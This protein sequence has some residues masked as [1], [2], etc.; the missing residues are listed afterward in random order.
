[1]AHKLEKFTVQTVKR[2]EIHEAD[3]N[4][5][6]IS[7]KN[8]T[9]LKKDLKTFGLLAPIVV[10]KTTGN[11]VAGHQRLSILDETAKDDYDIT[12]AYVELSEEDEI[13]ANVLMNNQSAMGE[14][15]FSKLEGLDTLIDGVKFDFI[16]DLG[17]DRDDLAVIGAA[18]G[19]DDFL[20]HTLGTNL[21][22]E[23]LDELEQASQLEKMKKQKAG[24]RESLKKLN[25]EGD[26]QNIS[27][28]DYILSFV[29]G[30]TP[31]KHEFMKKIQKKES[32]RFID[33]NILY[34]LERGE[35]HD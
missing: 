34:R 30:S 28:D 15:D 21:G 6:T 35:Y 23:E 33:A 12:V 7:D 8:R 14:W 1:M 19:N 25:E 27:K 18:T 9:R 13:K 5:R 32:E 4:P 3:Y 24:Q 22:K 29:F 31:E 26:Q 10:N 16:D 2:S 20:H 17:F 11:V